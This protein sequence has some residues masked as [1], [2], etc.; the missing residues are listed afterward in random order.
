MVEEWEHKPYTYIIKCPKCKKP[1]KHKKSQRRL[2][3][4]TP[5]GKRLS[6]YS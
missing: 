4:E 5:D 2:V 6:L 1:R 3:F